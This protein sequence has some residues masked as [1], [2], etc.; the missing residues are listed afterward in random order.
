MAISAKT[1]GQKRRV[2]IFLYRLI[3]NRSAS[4]FKCSARIVIIGMSA[5]EEGNIKV[6]K[7]QNVFSK[8]LS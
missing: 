4:N 3:L 5:V 2:N 8:G 1:Y 6:F 7:W